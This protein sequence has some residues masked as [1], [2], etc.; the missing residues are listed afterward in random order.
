MCGI[1]GIISKKDEILKKDI[2]KLKNRLK[3]RGLDDDG[4]F[5]DKKV[6]LGHTRLSILDLSSKAHQP[7]S[8]DNVIISYNGEVF[9]FKEIKNELQKKGIS[10]FS[11]SD[12]EVIL[13]AYN[14]YGIDFIKKLNGMFAFCIYD[15]NKNKIFLARD[16]YGIKPL[17]FYQDP[18][19]IIF[20]SEIKSILTQKN[21]TLTLDNDAMLDYL[22]FLY[23]KHPKTPFNE[24]KKV[25]PAFYYEVDLNT[26]NIMKTKYYTIVD[27]IDT[28]LKQ[29]DV[30]SNID[31]ILQK[32][33]KLRMI[34]DVEVGTFLSGGVDSSLITAMASK[35]TDKKIN[36]FSIGFKGIN[37]YFDESEYAVKISKKYNTNHTILDLNFDETFDD[38]EDIVYQ[39]DEPCA[40]TSLFLNYN[41]SKLT[42]QY[43]SVALSGLGGDE[44]F[45]GYNRHRAMHI[46]TYLKKFPNSVYYLQKI[47]SSFAT[48]R[49]TAIGNKLRHF[50]KLL[51]SSNHDINTSYL[52]M[53]KY[54]EIRNDGNLA[55]DEYNL[56]N[57][58]LRHEI[59]Y[60]M[61]DN[62]LN[63]TDKMS[64][65]HN[66]EIRTPFLDF[67]MVDF[68]FKVDEKY[69]VSCF[70][71]KIILKKLAE[72]Y[73]DKNIIYRRKQGFAAPIEI[74]LQNI[75]LKKIQ[76]FIDLNFLK[77]FISI[78]II[79]NDLNTFYTKNKDKS[80][81]IYSYIILSYWYKLNKDYL[82]G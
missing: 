9:N 67:N 32:S 64:M 15:K 79:M 69:K 60:Y 48:N 71:T 66:L 73:M 13:R 17:Y 63:L 51:L 82:N 43:V 7:M 81:Q 50:D 58:I 72:K 74:W 54:Q 28:T 19:K 10:F 53:I 31:E 55:L 46:M 65:A 30:V 26:L 42:K 44:L 11:N 24:I 29:E 27:K 1:C 80:L 76:D 16:R 40:D 62:L 33:V 61:N 78:E 8:I 22:E 34:S 12:T 52:Q 37:K 39:M 70:N 21:I 36:T 14:F 59:K 57:S 77:N 56:I 18:N 23:I 47:I 3:H 25:Q 35:I 20:S 5:I 45:G 68:A 6:A 49:T 2:E 4:I 38:I 41:I 75:G